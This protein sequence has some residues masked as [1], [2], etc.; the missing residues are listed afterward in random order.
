MNTI[1]TLTVNGKQYALTDDGARQQL[2][3]HSARIDDLAGACPIVCSAYG[4]P[5]SVEDAANYPIRTLRLYGK[6]VQSRIPTPAAPVPLVS[7]GDGDAV[8]VAVAGTELFAGW[9]PD[10]IPTQDILSLLDTVESVGR[11]GCYRS[12]SVADPTDIDTVSFVGSPE[13]SYLLILRATANKA[14]LALNKTTFGLVKLTLTHKQ[15]GAVT[16]FDFSGM[17]NADGTVAN[18]SVG[19]GAAD[20]SWVYENSNKANLKAESGYVR[21]KY[22]SAENGVTFLAFRLTG[23]SAGCYQMQ[24]EVIMQSGGAAADVYVLPAD[25]P[26]PIRICTV[27]TP[28]GL[29]GI[30]VSAG[31]NYI[32]ENGQQWLCNVLDLT[33][34]V[35]VQNVVK[36][37]FDQ[38]SNITMPSQKQT[39]STNVRFDF[40]NKSLTGIKKQDVTAPQVILCNYA[41]AAQTANTDGVWLNN[42]NNYFEGR[43]SVDSSVA[44]TVEEMKAL[45]AKEP[46][47][48]VVPLAE[49][50][51]TAADPKLVETFAGLRSYYPMTL[52]YND[53]EAG[54][55]LTYTADT[56][57]Y[58]D[59]TIA[60]AIGNG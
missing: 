5:I 50:V 43:L 11:V 14:G 47:E 42:T 18:L 56:K 51:E 59:R 23:I 1:K 22:G 30:P 33:R 15:T 27:A 53:G 9:Q 35:Y 36:A 20:G 13:D 26:R 44:A 32:D 16:V 57:S 24:F 6:T 17:A 39:P 55:E 40:V 46:I 8:G 29:P 31:G 41:P 49:P 52:V 54:M 19:D 2:T 10:A 48:F 58:I 28:N 25:A 3:Q 7:A 37:V 38:N 45:L 34:G 60:K 4:S 21:W 12:G